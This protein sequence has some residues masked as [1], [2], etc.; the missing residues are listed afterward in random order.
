VNAL[1]TKGST[2]KGPGLVPLGFSKTNHGGYQGAQIGTVDNG[3][4]TLSSPVYVTH[5]K[6]PIT[7][8]SAA[9]PAP[10]KL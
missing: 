1:N 2:Y 10:P 9:Q 8:Y 4:V 5:D 7:V 3:T 6:G